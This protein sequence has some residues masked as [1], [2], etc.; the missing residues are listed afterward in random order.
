MTG[1]R[2]QQ[3]GSEIDRSKIVKFTFDGRSFAGFE[4]D[5]I[6]SAL[7]ASGVKIFGRSFKYHR[8]RGVWGKGADEPNAIV[9]VKLGEA[10]TPNQRA[11]TTL[12]RDGMVVESVN[13][14]PNAQSDRYGFIDRLQRF[15]PAGF[16][17][18]TFMALNWLRYEPSIRKMAGLGKI[19][20]QFEPPANAPHIDQNCD[21]LIIGAGPA[22]L[23][24]AN[25]AIQAGRKVMLVDDASRP[26][27]SLLWR[28]GELDGLYW[29]DYVRQT[30]DLV[31]SSGGKILTNT[32]IWGAFD[33]G[34][35]AAW[36]RIMDGADRHLRIR[37]NDVVLAAGAIERPL[38][39]ANNDLP[40]VMSAEAA[41]V[42]LQC[43]GVI[44]GKRIVIA[45]ANDTTY[46][47]AATLA[48]AGAK[49]TVVDQRSQVADFPGDFDQIKGVTVT[50][51]IG[52]T[53]VTGAM[54]NGREL[55][56][57][58]LLCSGGFTPSVH[59]WCQSGG[60]LDWNADR[61]VLIPRPGTS[62][63]KVVG[64]ADGLPWVT[65]G[66]GVFST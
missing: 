33:H 19:D 41:M 5:T 25:A 45:T 26:G 38:W 9:D 43:Y 21:V 53:A 58:A 17:Y 31:Q 37:A 20:S 18:K 50:E 44:A 36:Q 34:M 6:A 60:K 65:V 32:M 59:I 39:F 24:A 63:I 7:L 11:T 66:A 35:F 14:A 27:G 55:R 2:H 4:G 30:C 61:D 47:C 46:S 12:L 16:Y 48:A 49:V 15:L 10:H 62:S 28:G 8:P 42:Q 29:E 23:S 40:G 64:A 54:V 1:W 56:C 57:D 51:V 13:A 52:K 3:L 22:G